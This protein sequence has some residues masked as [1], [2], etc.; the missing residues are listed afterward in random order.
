MDIIDDN[1]EK[2][3][4][5]LYIDD[6][7][8][9]IDLDNYPEYGKVIERNVDGYYSIFD[10]KLNDFNLKISNEILHTRESSFGHLLFK[11]NILC[12]FH[13]TKK[14]ILIDTKLV[15]KTVIEISYQDDK[16]FHDIFIYVFS[17]LEKYL[18]EK[19]KRNN[20]ILDDAYNVAKKFLSIKQFKI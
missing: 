2:I 4:N 11:D 14:Y 12:E 13:I 8:I 18:E 9:I 16:K 5:K 1:I 17:L 20:K 7:N 6:K 3:I 15:E 10:F 19:N